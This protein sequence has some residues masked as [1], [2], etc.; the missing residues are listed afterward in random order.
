MA[1]KSGSKTPQSQ[2]K[3]N[4]ELVLRALTDREFRKLLATA[5]EKAL[6]KSL[7]AVHKQEI[8]LVLASVK[9]IE[10]H[11]GA[12]ADNLLCVTNGH[13]GIVAA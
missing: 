12:L 13:C 3:V 10:F 5:P 9:G 4:K 7:T 6:G 8:S 1:K 2:K 11:I